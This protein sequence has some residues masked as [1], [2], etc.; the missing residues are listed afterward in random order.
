MR[1]VLFNA[2]CPMC[3]ER[4]FYYENEFGSKVWFD[5]LGVPWTKHPCFDRHPEHRT[6]RP[7]ELPE[8]VLE[9]EPTVHQVFSKRLWQK[10]KWHFFSVLKSKQDTRRLYPW[11]RPKTINIDVEDHERSIGHFIARHPINN[12]PFSLISWT[13]GAFFA[14]QNDA[15]ET[16]QVFPVTWR[17][18]TFDCVGNAHAQRVADCFRQVLLEAK[19]ISDPKD[20]LY[21][22]D[23]LYDQTD[24]P[25]DTIAFLARAPMIEVIKISNGDAKPAYVKNL[26]K[27]RRVAA[28][29]ADCLYEKL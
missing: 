8:F 4:C 13:D 12:G 26:G 9:L 1:Q 3:G 19:M 23:Q 24:L 20:R 14:I 17:S 21:L 16:R 2:T 6:T 28:A 22:A 5:E 27:V 29:I 15:A 11:E 25:I 7:K 10:E 18:K